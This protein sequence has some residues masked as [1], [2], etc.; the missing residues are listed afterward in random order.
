[1]IAG[2]SLAQGPAPIISKIAIAGNQRVEDDAIR[3]HISQQVGQPLDQAALD[4]DIKAIYKMGF[5]SNVE[6]EIVQQGG[7]NMLV[8]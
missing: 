8:Y 6:S 1:M 2:S 3:I 5:F 4:A 7:Q